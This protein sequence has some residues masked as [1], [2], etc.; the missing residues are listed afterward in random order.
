MT[1][2]A[3]PRAP[4][5]ARP[6]RPAPTPPPSGRPGPAVGHPDDLAT[7][8]LTALTAAVGAGANR[9]F[10]GPHALPYLVGAAA[11]AHLLAWAGRRLGI[12][13]AAAAVSSAVTALLVTIWFVIPGATT[14][15]VPTPRTFGALSDLA[16][17]GQTAFSTAVAPAVPTPG[18][19]AGCVVAI[20]LAA[21]LA[22]WAA[23]RMRTAF[24]ACVPALALF[25]LACVLGARQGRALATAGFLVAAGVFLVVQLAALD[26]ERA[27][28]FAGRTT[29]ATRSLVATGGVVVAA[30]TLVA[31]AVAPAVPGYGSKAVVSTKH[32][33]NSQSLDRKIASPLVTIH[34]RLVDTSA[35]VVFTVRAS[36]PS[37]W[38]LTSL[39]QFNGDV[40]SISESYSHTRGRLG[41]SAADGTPT[42]PTIDASF[43][44][45]RLDSVW[46]AAPYLPVQVSGLSGVSYNPESG[47][48]IPDKDTSDG[49]T[50]G[51]RSVK[52]D[53][54]AAQL[55]QAPLGVPADMGRY[56]QLPAVPGPVKALAQK[57]VAQA[58]TPY[59]RALAIQNYLRT[60]TYS[61]TAEQGHGTNV[62]EHFLLQTKT[63]YCEQFA[64]S[65]GV[66]ARLA[67]LPTRVAVGFRE[68][69][70]NGNG[71]YTVRDEDAHAWPEVW[72]PGT[73]WVDFEP[74]PSRGAP[75]GEGHTGVAPA[76]P[77]PDP[78]TAAGGPATTTSPQ[79][80]APTVG[81]TTI[82]GGR[83]AAAPSA[84]PHANAATATLVAILVVLAWVILV[85]GLLPAALVGVVVG[86]KRQRRNARRRR[87]TTPEARVS[88]AW[89]EAQETLDES[90]AG[91]HAGETIAEYVV[92]LSRGH[93]SGSRA[94]L[95]PQSDALKAMG[96][97]ASATA[98][99]AY[100]P[101]GPGP[102]VAAQAEDD[103]DTVLGALAAAQSPWRRVRTAADPRRLWPG[104]SAGAAIPR[105]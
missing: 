102:E 9:M 37:Y 16:R 22:D 44:I 60:F 74:T 24:E 38:R 53:P 25:V 6:P 48:L 51:I 31:L 30:V 87:A 36:A 50:Y 101:D 100:A 92:R 3:P 64:G 42:G 82:P 79:T 43:T 86:L 18:F 65:Y 8:C 7:L 35:Q 55:A 99:S 71:T 26:G 56:L 88:L 91:R 49:L 41:L 10:S 105:A 12:G 11:V 78:G 14:F 98:T 61:L 84:H 54:S 2:V 62:L 67:G 29:G 66:L 13:T 72:F 47:S 97:L 15:G 103:R 52:P 77:A 20:T 68:G 57:I 81:Q 34:S 45:G 21:F 104:R 69:V 89:S 95:A 73:G 27:N 59:E 93:G 17:T 94:G 40:W 90:G 23:F 58:R 46:L 76:P 28:W 4:V 75:T 70:D 85:F 19:I 96:G 33:L 80:T 32:D 5:Q 1:A 63:G 83:E 39:D